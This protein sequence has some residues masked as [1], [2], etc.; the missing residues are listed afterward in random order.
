MNR[1]V[2]HSAPIG[3]TGRSL[4]RII[5]D[6]STGWEP[7]DIAGAAWWY[8]PSD[9]D[10]VPRAD[11]NWV[12]GVTAEHLLRR[13]V[14][15]LEDRLERLGVDRCRAIV[16]EDP[17]PSQIKAG[18]P[19]HRL[20]QIRERFGELVQIVRTADYATA[21]WM[22]HHSPAHAVCFRFGLGDLTGQYRLL[23]EA[24]GYGTGIIAQAPTQVIWKP[25]RPID[26]ATNLAYVASRPEVNSVLIDAG[27]LGV[28]LRAF[29]ARSIEEIRPA[30]RTP[31]DWWEEFRRQVPE[32]PKPERQHPPE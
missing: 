18:G 21:E 6:A 7:G 24:A 16:L 30:Q 26:P 1:G 2:I 4:A 5:V 15:W 12:V 25:D 3:R 31:Q 9:M 11:L 29:G 22:V 23:G 17:A 14:R 20:N 27:D 32:P 10:Q 13:R 28:A 8:V 19:F